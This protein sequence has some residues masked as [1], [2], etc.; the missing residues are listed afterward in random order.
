MTAPLCDALTGRRA[1]QAVLESLERAHLFVVPLDDQRQW[2]RYHDLFGRA[3]RAAAVPTPRPAARAARRAHGRL[4]RARAAG[5]QKLR[6]HAPNAVGNLRF[7]V[8]LGD[9]IGNPRCRVRNDT[10]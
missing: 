6:H 8:T 4:G 10:T 7:D 2:Y 1:G 3:P 5:A 9:G